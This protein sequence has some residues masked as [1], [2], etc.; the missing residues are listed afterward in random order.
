MLAGNTKKSRNSMLKLFILV[1]LIFLFPISNVAADYS[2]DFNQTKNKID[3]FLVSVS[4]YVQKPLLYPLPSLTVSAK[5]Y[6]K[7][8]G[9]GLANKIISSPNFPAIFA[10]LNSQVAN[11]SSSLS[12]R[13]NESANFLSSLKKTFVAPISNIANQG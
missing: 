11:I 10:R 7:N 1:S 2:L 9:T 4:S 5:S 13:S 6:L 3:S 8:N 12:D